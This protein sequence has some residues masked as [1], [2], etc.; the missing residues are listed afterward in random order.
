VDDKAP[1]V[2]DAPIAE[3]FDEALRP[4]GLLLD[5]CVL[6]L[7][8]RD[9][10]AGVRILRRAEL[11]LASLCSH[12]HLGST[13]AATLLAAREI[14]SAH[15]LAGAMLTEGGAAPGVGRNILRRGVLD[16]QALLANLRQGD[17]RQ[18]VLD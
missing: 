6:A 14:L 17:A 11:R 10:G 15:L 7:E 12:E 13:T 8:R 18:L 5:S 1:S 3:N 4:A 9:V 16:C 2:V